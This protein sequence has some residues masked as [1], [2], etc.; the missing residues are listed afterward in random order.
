MKKTFGDGV[1][2]QELPEDGAPVLSMEDPELEAGPKLE[3]RPCLDV[4]RGHLGGTL[5][6]TRHVHF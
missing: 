6:S 4:P 2:V 1:P 5:E 3:A